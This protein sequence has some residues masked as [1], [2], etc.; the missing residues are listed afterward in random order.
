MYQYGI[1]QQISAHRSGDDF[2]LSCYQA[3]SEAEALAQFRAEFPNRCVV[4]V[5]AES[6]IDAGIL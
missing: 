4:G 6:D 2:F 3:F 1:Y 5:Y